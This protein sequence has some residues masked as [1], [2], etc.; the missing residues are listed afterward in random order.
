MKHTDPFSFFFSCILSTVTIQGKWTNAPR[1]PT[2]SRHRKTNKLTFSVTGKVIV[3]QG[4]DE[5]HQGQDHD[6]GA[7]GDASAPVG[8]SRAPRPWRLVRRSGTNPD[9]DVIRRAVGRRMV[10]EAVRSRLQP[11]L[12]HFSIVPLTAES[13]MELRVFFFYDNNDNIF[14]FWIQVVNKLSSRECRGCFDGSAGDGCPANFGNRGFSCTRPTAGFSN[15][16]RKGDN[17]FSISVVICHL[18]ALLF[19]YFFVFF[20]IIVTVLIFFL[21]N[22][23]I[24]YNKIKFTIAPN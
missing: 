6:D 20:L 3:R 8:P 22:C 21:T 10:K 16:D 24:I 5:E 12:S 7:E 15:S 13:V 14:Y 19:F 23:F 9:G 4:G 1:L 18:L 2:Y 11:V 17:M